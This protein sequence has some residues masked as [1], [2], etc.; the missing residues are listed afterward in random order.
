MMERKL[1]RAEG[2]SAQKVQEEIAQ[3]MV[4][5]GFLQVRETGVLPDG[6]QYFHGKMTVLVHLECYHTSKETMLALLLGNAAQF[7]ALVGRH[8]SDGLYLECLKDD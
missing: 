7:G 1:Y 6:D 5:D 3:K 8:S 4:D 2:P